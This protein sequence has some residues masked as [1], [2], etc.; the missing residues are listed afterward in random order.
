MINCECHICGK[1]AKYR[2]YNINF[3]NKHRSYNI[4]FCNK[5]WD[6]FLKN[7]LIDKELNNAKRK[8]KS[9]PSF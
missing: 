3:C 7:Q 2:S 5:H 9:E 4:N 8:A 1:T 6:K